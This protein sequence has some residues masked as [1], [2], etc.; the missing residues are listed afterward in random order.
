MNLQQV[1]HISNII[2]KSFF[3]VLKLFSVSDGKSP[4][5]HCMSI[6]LIS[7][8]VITEMLYE[9]Q[10]LKKQLMNVQ[11]IAL[12]GK[13]ENRNKKYEMNRLIIN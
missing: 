8:C 4:D 13:I 3:F 10:H 1:E 12:R 5:I 2:L 11:I 6:S 7:K 9:S